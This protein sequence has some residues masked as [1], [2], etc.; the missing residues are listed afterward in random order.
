MILS[1]RLGKAIEEESQGQIWVLERSSDQRMEDRI[2]GSQG[3]NHGG[4]LA[5]IKKLFCFL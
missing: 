5:K 1:Y 4:E 2:R 3:K